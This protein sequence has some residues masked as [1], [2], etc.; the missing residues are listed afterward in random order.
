MANIDRVDFNLFRLFEALYEERSVSRAAERLFITPSAVS[1][2]LRRIRMMMG[3]ELFTRGPRGMLPTPRAHAVAAQLRILLPQLAE[4]I[5][6]PDFDPA[7]TD[8]TFAVAC[9]PYLTTVLLPELVADVARRAPN[10]RLDL[11]LI[12]NSVVDDLDSGALDVALG[13]FRRTPPRFVAEEILRDSYVW[14]I[15]RDHPAAARRLTVELLSRLPHIDIHIDSQAKN[16][17]ESFDLRQGLERLVIQNGIASLEESLL[18][19]GLRRRVATS[20][21]DSLAGM[22]AVSRS[23][24]VCLVPESAATRF[25]ETFGLMRLDPPYKSAPLVIQSLTHADYRE[26][27][28]I[29]WLLECIRSAAIVTMRQTRD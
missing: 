25:G 7:A 17:V 20:V 8:R 26:K 10:A 23:D 11:R 29:Q 5:A 15:R 3:D 27:P 9:V 6:P 4:V 13:H 22:A 28:A 2:A 14:V 16:T 19:A 18:D 21:P 1:H 24:A 12:Y